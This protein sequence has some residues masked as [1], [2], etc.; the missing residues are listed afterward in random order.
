MTEKSRRMLR[1]L[2]V[3]GLATGGVCRPAVV[4]GQSEP[5]GVDT[6]VNLETPLYDELAHLAD[7]APDDQAE[8]CNAGP[9]AVKCQLWAQFRKALGMNSGDDDH[10]VLFVGIA[11]RNRV[12]VFH[13]ESGALPSVYR[14]TLGSAKYFWAAY[15]EDEDG[16]RPFETT[17]DVEFKKSV[18]EFDYEQFDAA[19]LRGMADAQ[20]RTSTQRPVRLGANRFKVRPPPVGIEVSFTRQGIAY[21]T[22]QWRATYRVLSNNSLELNGG[23]FLPGTEG[24]IRRLTLDTVA[25][26]SNGTP[27]AYEV[28]LDETRRYAFLTIGASFSQ[29]RSKRLD[30][31][32]WTRNKF[33]AVPDV[34][35]GLGLPPESGNNV[36]YF[37]F[38]WPVPMERVNF[39]I[40]WIRVGAQESLRTG[41][42][43]GAVVPA[44][45]ARND[46]VDRQP[47]WKFT[48]GLYV[49][50][51]NFRVW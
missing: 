51:G 19:T 30:S 1:T 9:T 49:N 43:Q 11:G 47:A 29:A 4:L 39:A 35:F 8:K 32:G 5:Y 37:G 10:I 46:L 6:V 16:L 20:P 3:L 48:F 12:M 36:Y 2:F 24:A 13:E 40:G 42:S 22:R 26:G 17:I 14:K 7:R 18:A 27:S 38:A 23:I 45:A 21:G 34:L 44:P 50:M 33:T 41:L 28:G 31:V 15:V 25:R